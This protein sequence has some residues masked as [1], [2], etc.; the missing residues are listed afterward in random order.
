[1]TSVGGHPIDKSRGASER[2]RGR[3][4][5]SKREGKEPIETN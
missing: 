5:G 2:A 4:M 3:A 1:V